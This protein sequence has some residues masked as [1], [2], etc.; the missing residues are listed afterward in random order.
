MATNELAIRFTED[1]YATK[2]EVSKELKMS[3]I[4]NIWSN[5]LNYRSNF[6]RYLTVKSIEKNQLLICYCP[7]VSASLTALEAKLLRGLKDFTRLDTK[8]GDLPYFETTCVVNALKALVKEY[9]LDVDETYL[10]NLAKGDVREISKEHRILYRYKKSLDFVCNNYHKPID[11]DYLAALYSAFTENSQLTTFYR[12]QDDDNPENRVLIDRVYTCAPS[13]LIDSMMNSLFAFIE[14]SPVTG[15][16]KAIVTYYY[17]NYIRPFLTHSDEIAL[18]LAK[19]ILAHFDLDEYAVYLP[20]EKILCDDAAVIAKIFVEVQ[21][22]NDLTYFVNFMVKFIEKRIEETADYLTQREVQE[23]HQDL[24]Q[25]DEEP[26]KEV[27]ELVEEKKEEPVQ[28]A[29]EEPKVEPVKIIEKTIYVKEEKVEPVVKSS[30]SEEIAVSYIPPV[31]DEKQA[32]RLEEHLLELEPTMKRG[33]ARFYARHCTMGK[34]YTIQQYKK[35]IGCAYETARTSMDHLV[36]LGYYRK[37]MVKNKN[38]Y[39]PMKQK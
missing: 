29:I 22:T 25:V 34:R 27:V 21:K 14:N 11:V 16:V 19:S 38:V 23:L 18:L 32:A 31:L 6:N 7:S 2:S 15:L 12:S 28:P 5:I 17:V 36:E 10:R 24:Y 33:E 1:N 20:L 26:V 3:L 8:S 39:T 9:D 13:T 30:Q 4:D 35:S 37:E